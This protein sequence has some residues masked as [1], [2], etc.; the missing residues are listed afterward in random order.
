MGEIPATVIGVLV[1]ETPGTVVL[2]PGTRVRI[3]AAAEAEV[4]TVS[5][6]A[7]FPVAEGL[8]APAAWA[9]APAG[10]A[11]A[12]HGAAVHAAHPAWDPVAAPGAAAGGGGE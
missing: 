4:E 11:A 8:A 2:E 7:A 10:T 12:A 6:T 5:A 1:G 9:A 3:V